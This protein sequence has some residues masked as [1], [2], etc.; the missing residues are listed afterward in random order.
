MHNA[1]SIYRSRFTPHTGLIFLPRKTRSS[2]K[3]G[4]SPPLF[5]SSVSSLSLSLSLTSPL[6]KRHHAQWAMSMGRDCCVLSLSYLACCLLLA[7]CCLMCVGCCLL[8]VACCSLLVAR[9]LLLVACCSL[10]VACCFLCLDCC[11]DYILCPEEA[12]ESESKPTQ[13]EECKFNRHQLVCGKAVGSLISNPNTFTH[14]S[15]EPHST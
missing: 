7:A 1:N 13:I 3:G 14:R 9:C 4:E 10:L 11:V 6:P 5:L 8:L 2:N 15:Q 12:C